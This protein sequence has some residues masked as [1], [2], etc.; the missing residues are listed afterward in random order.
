MLIENYIHN[1]YFVKS[2]LLANIMIRY[3]NPIGFCKQVLTCR[4]NQHNTNNVT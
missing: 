3:I 2:V 1:N 4:T